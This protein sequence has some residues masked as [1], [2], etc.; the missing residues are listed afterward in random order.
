[1]RAKTRRVRPTLL[2]L[3][4]LGLMLLL[5]GCAGAPSGGA[6]RTPTDPAAPVSAPTAPAPTPVPTPPPYAELVQHRWSAV[7]SF[8]PEEWDTDL[9]MERVGDNVFE[10]ELWLERGDELKARMDEGWTVNFG[11]DGALDGVNCAAEARGLYTLRLELFDEERAALE[12]IGPLER[13]AAWSAVG[14]IGGGDWDR[15]LPLHPAGRG[16]Y[17]RELQGLRAGEEL[18]ACPAG[19]P[20]LAF[21][22]D[23]SP[24]GPALTVPADG[25]Y[26]LWLAE[27]E[28]GEKRLELWPRETRLS[29][30]CAVGSIY[31]SRWQIDFPL[32][33]IGPDRAVLL[34]PDLRAG[35]ELLLR[36]DGSWARVLGA[37]GPGDETAL[38]VPADGNYLLE[39]QEGESGAELR[40]LPQDADPGQLRLQARLLEARL[41]ARYPLC[42]H[43]GQVYGEGQV[44]ADSDG[45]LPGILRQLR[46]LEDLL[47]KL[48]AGFPEELCGPVPG[49]ADETERPID[50]YLVR[51]VPGEQVAQANA[52]GRHMSLV[53]QC[54]GESAPMAAAHELMHLIDRRLTLL[55]AGF[56][57]DWE[58]L[59]PPGLA[60]AED[61]A[62][63]RDYFVSDY[64]RLSP[65]EDRAEVFAYLFHRSPRDESGW[66]AGRPGLERKALA[67]QQAIR[68]AFPSVRALERAWWER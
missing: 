57:A 45:D 31:A 2:A 44:R 56:E 50:V 1:M 23:G 67:L 14:T 49:G 22:A 51:E 4:A 33:Q 61:P 55:D 46:L 41:M 24:D 64:A 42:F 65:A 19:E 8:G 21:G 5:G 48:P 39:L 16:I 7:G 13:D 15:E 63:W 25:D 6:G 34:C 54:G 30:W 58:A 12:L 28:S 35:E 53:F 27:A 43:P 37:V 10:V 20:G 40:L 62:L 18:R 36:R 60:Q 38:T 59:T 9:P 32:T 52:W 29:E 26:V 17:A 68:A 47:Q 11:A 3:A 66:C